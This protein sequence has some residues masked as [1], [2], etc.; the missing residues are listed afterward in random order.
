M[1]RR[2]LL[3]VV[4][5]LAGCAGL[6]GA[7]FD[8]AHLG[9]DAHEDD[10]A[11]EGAAFDVIPQD[12]APEVD[13]AF[14]PASLPNLALWLDATFGVDLTDAGTGRVARWHDRSAYARD[15]VPVGAG[16]NPP[17][18]VP[19]SLGGNSVVHFTSAALDLL[20][21]AWSGPGVAELTMFLVTRGLPNS[22]V[23]FQTSS[24]AYPFLIFPLNYNLPDAA[25]PSFHFAVGLTSTFDLQI[26]LDGSASVATARW[27]SDGTASTFLDGE[28]V[29]QRIAASPT[30]PSGQTLYIGGTLPLL[31]PPQTTIPFAD[32]DVAEIVVY[33]A[34]LA[35]A[36][37]A[38]V[39]AYLRQK[40]GLP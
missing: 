24:G 30:L 20:E 10:G 17:S 9:A 40:W 25:A 34:A 3:V 2:A 36:D 8:D 28:L 16:T 37:R 14:D 18:L 22:A 29:E 35:D 4:V 32:G 11:A 33:A 39:E 5:P 19:A 1:K 27:R 38:A 31:A 26:D 13:A 21:S 6:I 15:A 7:S 23:R 12:V